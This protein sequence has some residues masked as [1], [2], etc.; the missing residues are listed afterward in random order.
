MSGTDRERSCRSLRVVSSVPSLGGRDLL[1]KDSSL[2]AATETLC[3]GMS[4]SP[5]NGPCG[6]AIVIH[7][8]LTERKRTEASIRELSGWLIRAQE[9]ERS[10]IARELHDDI[11][12]QLALLEIEIQRDGRSLAGNGRTTAGSAERDLEKDTRGF[13]GCAEDFSSTAFFQVAVSGIG[14]GAEGPAPGI[15]TP[16][17]SWRRNPASGHTDAA[18]QRSFVDLVSRGTRGAAERGQAQCSQEHSNGIDR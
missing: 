15:H 1:N 8:D 11:N 4:V 12:Q 6:A 7:R 5:L 9:E 13:T 10:R 2:P 14:C 17:P 16:V 3:F 18:G